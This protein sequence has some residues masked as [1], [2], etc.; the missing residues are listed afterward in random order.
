MN[1]RDT[2][3]STWNLILQRRILAAALAVAV[4]AIEL[5]PLAA[6]A[7][8]FDPTAKG[9]ATRAASE[10]AGLL[11]PTVDAV[12]FDTLGVRFYADTTVGLFWD[13]VAI[14]GLTTIAIRVHG[15]GSASIVVPASIDVSKLTGFTP[16]PIRIQPDAPGPVLAVVDLYAVAG[17]GAADTIAR[18]SILITATAVAVDPL[19][20]SAARIV[21]AENLPSDSV[22]FGWVHLDS[23]SLRYGAWNAPAAVIPGSLVTQ[24][25]VPI[26]GD[27]GSL[28]V[29]I[30]KNPAPLHDSAG[31]S[32]V[33]SCCDVRVDG[34]LAATWEI[35]SSLGRRRI[36]LRAR[37]GAARLLLP[38]TVSF[39]LIDSCTVRPLVITNNG[40]GPFPLDVTGNLLSEAFHLVGSA[41]TVLHIPAGASDTLL[42][43][44]CPDGTGIATGVDSVLTSEGAGAVFLSRTVATSRIA[45]V[46]SL[47]NVVAP[48]GNETE[49]TLDVGTIARDSS[50]SR[51]YRFIVVGS[52]RLFADAPVHSGSTAFDV[53]PRTAIAT[54]SSV[55]TVAF[56][57]E[58]HP[59]N[60]TSADSSLAATVTYDRPWD[61][62]TLVLHL[63]G[64]WRSDTT[65][66]ARPLVSPHRLDFSPV[67]T[68]SCAVLR[69]T[70][71]NPTASPVT[72]K[73]GSNEFRIEVPASNVILPGAVADT[74]VV[75]FCPD[76]AST[77]TA[78]LMLQGTSWID[79]VRLQG[80]GTLAEPDVVGLTLQ[81][82]DTAAHPGDT[83]RLALRLKSTSG[84]VSLARLFASIAY[85]SLSLFPVGVDSTPAAPAFTW[86]VP[87]P[88]RL[89]L[90]YDKRV[91]VQPGDVA[92]AQFV[93]LSTG[94]T[95]TVVSIDTADAGTTPIAIGPDA[96]VRL[97]F[98]DAGRGVGVRTLARLAAASRIVSGGALTVSYQSPAGIPVSL[99]LVAV[100]GTEAA[101]I[102]LPGGDGSRRT[103]RLALEGIPPGFY[104][105]ELQSGATHGAVT[106]LIQR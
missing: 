2:R 81:G 26:E 32:I 68:D 40:R 4:L 101:R 3:P 102:E 23:C 11:T 51:Q 99:R 45:L 22:D 77:F 57:V 5:S 54:A 29:Q 62:P 25:A 105:L 104:V 43:E 13:T 75:R 106:V 21:G 18:D 89:V 15:T 64:S 35:R 94:S 53:T 91:E 82:D 52:A 93:A 90:E 65:V 6:R 61:D 80:E 79:S 42:V 7:D 85:D 76:S 28:L 27:T 66:A 17:N 55:D 50:L 8:R 56:D 14:K 72:L 34:D 73:L 37:I 98:C 48:S 92:I 58:F 96:I 33:A 100:D 70:V 10:G 83:V 69:L 78:W 87:T 84:S 19:V 59:L 95:S 86:T 12:A 63:L 41:D 20:G 97:P 9:S 39:G 88:G 67:P 47:G 36:V 71:S 60:D 103:E 16:V 74:V 1:H 31:A 38:Q 44:T 24:T 46:D 30:L 49:W